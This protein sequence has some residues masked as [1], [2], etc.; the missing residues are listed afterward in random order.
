MAPPN[1]TVLISTFT[2]AREWKKPDWHDLAKCLP[3]NNPAFGRPTLAPSA[4][5][6]ETDADGANGIGV[7]TK[8][9]PSTSPQVTRKRPSPG[10]QTAKGTEPALPVK[11]HLL[12]IATECFFPDEGDVQAITIRLEHVSD[13]TWQRLKTI[14][15][16]VTT[17]EMKALSEQ[18]PH[19]M[20]KVDFHSEPNVTSPVVPTVPVQFQPTARLREEY[21]ERKRNLFRRLLKRVPPR[22][23]LRYRIET[24]RPDIIDATTDK[25]APKPYH[26]STKALGNRENDYDD[27]V[28]PLASETQPKKG[29]KKALEPEVTFE[30]PV[31]LDQLD[32][33]VAENALKGKRGKGED[34][35][36]GKGRRWVPG[37]IC[38]GCGLA[39]KRVWRSGPGGKSTCE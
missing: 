36:K 10:S 12:N 9:S 19:L 29:N 33:M 34:G 32:E 35:R 11:S 16:M 24:P 17:A 23:F 15:G 28:I 3:F 7:S 4:V 18:S 22:R 8:E 38:Q 25:W 31:S 1:G 2:P 21:T 37:T 30:M 14:N 13:H 26:I 5:K 27:Q 39:N 6:S 20:D